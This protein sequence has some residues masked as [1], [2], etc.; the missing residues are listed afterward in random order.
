MEKEGHFQTRL[1]NS[2]GEGRE[3]DGEYFAGRLESFFHLIAR[4]AADDGVNPQILA[5]FLCQAAVDVLERR[6]G[7]TLEQAANEVIKQGMD[8]ATLSSELKS[9]GQ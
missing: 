2:A 5:A 6:G 3:P 4:D 7:M 8:I 1:Q 9:K